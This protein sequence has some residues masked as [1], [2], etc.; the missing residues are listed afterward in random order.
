MDQ[1][2]QASNSQKRSNLCNCTLE[3]LH[4]IGWHDAL[5][6]AQAELSNPFCKPSDTSTLEGVRRLN[7]EKQ[8]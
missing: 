4:T 6:K 7:K 1:P 3:P 2:G 5:K 8:K